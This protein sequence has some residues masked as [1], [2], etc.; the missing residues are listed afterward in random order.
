MNS[1]LLRRR[2]EKTLRRVAQIRFTG[3]LKRLKEASNGKSH[4]ITDFMR[5]RNFVTL[6][7]LLYLI[8]RYHIPLDSIL[9]GV[10]PSSMEVSRI[11]RT[12][13]GWLSNRRKRE[14]VRREMLK[15]LE[16]AKSVSPA[17]LADRLGYANCASLRQVDPKL[18][19]RIQSRHN[20]QSKREPRKG[21]LEIEAVLKENRG[22][23]NPLSLRKLGLKH[24]LPEPRA[25]RHRFPELC[26][27]ID[28]KRQQLF[29]SE[30]KRIAEGMKR[31]LKMFPPMTLPQVGRLLGVTA[32]KLRFHTHLYRRLVQRFQR[33]RN[34]LIAEQRVLLTEMLGEYPPP[35]LSEARKRLGITQSPMINHH[36]LAR[37]LVRRRKKYL[38]KQKKEHEKNLFKHIFE[39]VRTLVAEGR[40]VTVSSVCPRDEEAR[41]RLDRFACGTYGRAGSQAVAS[42][43]RRPI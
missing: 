6:E 15:A 12:A 17:A 29:E 3:S 19:R 34:N 27:G 9:F 25:L 7:N 20:S 18:Y 33:H 16:S 1:R 14:Y 23:K 5:G 38:V 35:N 36:G 24:R 31:A 39:S 30:H 37:Q 13:P 2:L 26:K 32:A 40:S 42:T 41:N 4:V 10:E 28:R 8:R 11:K 22:R 21:P 43:S